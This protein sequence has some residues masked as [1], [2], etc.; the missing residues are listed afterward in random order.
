MMD[1]ETLIDSLA[2][3]V[4]P[5]RHSAARASLLLHCL[6]GGLVA[7]VVVALTIGFRPDLD[8][9]MQGG[10]FWMKV[11]YTGS[12]AL[13]AL[14]GTLALARPESAVPRW[15][16]FAALPFT[17]LAIVSIVEAA[18]MEHD[19]WM[20]LWMGSSWRQ[21]PA[22]IVMLALPI[23]AALI[24]ALRQFAP[25]RLRL[26]GGVAGMAAGALAATFYCLHCPEVGA[27]FVLTWYTLGIVAV[28]VI[29]AIAGPRLLRW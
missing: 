12:L 8:I 19:A 5:A 1:T 20:S 6:L 21:C 28:A 10:L 26:T 23:G 22:L 7:I 11:S 18:G 16:W 13:I 4:R 15:L 29:G 27:A 25:T 24:H 3:G 9:A 14:A 2:G 17:A